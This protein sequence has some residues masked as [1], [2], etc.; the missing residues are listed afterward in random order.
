MTDVKESENNEMKIF[1]VNSL[2]TTVLEKI[3]PTPKIIHVLF[4][5]DSVKI[6]SCG[7]MYMMPLLYSFDKK[8][9][10]AKKFNEAVELNCV[11]LNLREGLMKKIKK[12]E[13]KCYALRIDVAESKWD[14]NIYHPTSISFIKDSETINKINAAENELSEVSEFKL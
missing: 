11:F 14:E 7:A 8:A 4:K 5:P 6:S 2:V 3:K 12:M 13:Y 10:T 9:M 1:S